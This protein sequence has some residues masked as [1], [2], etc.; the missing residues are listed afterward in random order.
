[1]EVSGQLHNDSATLPPGKS[2][3]YSLD[4]R[5]GGPQILSERN[6]EEKNPFIFPVCNPVCFKVTHS[7]LLGLVHRFLIYIILLRKLLRLY[8]VKC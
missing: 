8:G 3:R 2:P 7:E 5:L 6:G 1:M 4:R